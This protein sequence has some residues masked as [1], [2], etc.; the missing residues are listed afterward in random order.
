[1]D[2]AARRGDHSQTP[3]DPELLANLQSGVYEPFIPRN[4]LV[5][6]AGNLF[7]P[8]NQISVPGPVPTIIIP[9][10]YPGA[11]IPPVPQDYPQWTF[12]SD[13]E[14]KPVWRLLVD[15]LQRGH[16]STISEEFNA[17]ANGMHGRTQICLAERGALRNYPYADI[18][19]IVQDSDFPIGANV[20]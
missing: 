5:Q 4:P 6:P 13:G 1:M 10:S 18:W 7:T 20:L 14:K 19:G 8:A 17:Y 12:T 11:P 2:P 16:G 15:R 3:I 9:Y